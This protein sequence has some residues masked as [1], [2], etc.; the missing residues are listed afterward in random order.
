MRRYLVIPVIAGLLVTLGA[1]GAK[2]EPASTAASLPS[3]SSSDESTSTSTT[4]KR[5]TTTDGTDEDD[6][7]DTV[8]IP[9][10]GELPAGLSDECTTIITVFSSVLNYSLASMNPE[11]APEDFDQLTT[12]IENAKDDVPAELED[13]F[14][15][16][17]DAWAEFATLM[18]DVNADGGMSNPANLDKLTQATTVIET[19]EVEAAGKEIEDYLTAECDGFG[20]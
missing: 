6:P 17:S 18:E 1:C 9:G 14:G 7:T 12:D 13:A 8:T 2:E 10:G 19:P 16:W 3:A 20:S 11:A 5:S 4:E 15:T